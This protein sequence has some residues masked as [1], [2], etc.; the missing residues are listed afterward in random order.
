MLR[1]MTRKGIERG[2][3]LV[4]LFTMC[5][6]AIVQIRAIIITGVIVMALVVG[7]R[8]LPNMS[9][10]E[11]AIL[12]QLALTVCLLVLG[13]VLGVGWWPG[14]AGGAMGLIGVWLKCRGGP[15]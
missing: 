14:V 12:A 10:L 3:W 15:V 6:G 8:T 9:K 11:R 4:G 7:L 1:V 13:F 2:T 5:F